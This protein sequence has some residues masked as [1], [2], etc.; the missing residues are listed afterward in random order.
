MR[1]KSE[2][3]PP[4]GVDMPAT[5]RGSKGLVTPGQEAPFGPEERLMVGVEC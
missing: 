2:K 5:R 3:A 1:W 4:T